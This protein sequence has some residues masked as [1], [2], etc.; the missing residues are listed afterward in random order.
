MTIR[1]I[2][3]NAGEVTCYR[4]RVERK[5][6]GTINRSFKTEEEAINFVEQFHKHNPSKLSETRNRT[7]IVIRTVLE[8]PNRYNLP[9]ETMQINGCTLTRGFGRCAPM[10]ECPHYLERGTG[11]L[12]M[13]ERAGWEGWRADRV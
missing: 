5:K 11:C 6:T 8:H 3:N 4:A 13:A 7:G 9:P 12:D 1:R 10:T 2:I